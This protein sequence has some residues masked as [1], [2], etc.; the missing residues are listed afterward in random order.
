MQ[1]NK[2]NKSSNSVAAGAFILAISLLA[3]RFLGLLRNRIM[4]GMFGA[5]IEFDIYFAAFR[6]PDLIYSV[7][8]GGAISAAFIPVFISYFTRNQ[9][10]AWEIAQSFF[11]IVFAGII[12]VV[13]V[14]YFFMPRL[15]GLVVPGFSPEYRNIVTAMSRIMLLSS[16]LLGL[17]AIFSGI[18]HSFR[19]FFIYSLAPIFYNIGIIIGA[20]FFTQFFGIMGLAWGVA[21][22]ALLH[23]LIQVPATVS[24][25]FNFHFPKKLFHPAIF[26]IMRLMAP[27]ALGLAV[28]QINLLVIT[29]IASTLAVGSLTVFTL[30]NH[31]QYLPIG[32]VGISFATA[33]FPSLSQSFSK[34]KYSQYLA[35]LS[36]TLRTVFYLVFPLSVL[37]YILRAQVVRIVLGA[38]EFSWEATQLTAASLGAFSIGI[39]AYALTP[40]LS[41]AFYAQENTKTPVIANTIGIVVN[42]VLSLL[43]IY[44]IFPKSGM[45]QLVARVLKIENLSSV[46]VIGLP[47]AFSISGIIAFTLLLLAFFKDSKNRSIF[48][49]LISA[50]WRI[51]F[52]S[53]FVGIIAWFMLQIFVLFSPTNT[54]FRILLQTTISATI[55]LTAYFLISYLFKF[56]E[57][58]VFTRFIK[59]KFSRTISIQEAPL[60][61]PD[62]TS[63]DM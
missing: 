12:L 34:D 61:T 24:S 17:S 47:I 26:R 22:G 35:E 56:E 18:L 41:R 19:K 37:L 3:S 25:G 33:V 36:R 13:G 2:I 45:Q 53:I 15:T 51:F 59:K 27:R 58:Q 60:S 11:Y 48:R 40:V 63:G 4:A 10:E 54:L 43:L 46:S 21:L 49:E 23:M 20:V 57:F 30:A 29:A 44:V 5:G 1:F 52:T 7:I 39:F 14:V 42:I 55:A 16:F 6:I 9:K 31:I 62:D 38:G 28:Y 32:V 8:I 50:F